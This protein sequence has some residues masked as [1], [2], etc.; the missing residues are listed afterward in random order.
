VDNDFPR[1]FNHLVDRGLGLAISACGHEG[2]YLVTYFELGEHGQYPSKPLG[3]LF[4][5]FFAEA[6]GLG[7]NLMFITLRK[8][9]VD[10]ADIESD[11]CIDPLLDNL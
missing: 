2:G 7:Q 11:V 5:R 8:E 4:L 3:I 10:L 6:D 9:W 1:R